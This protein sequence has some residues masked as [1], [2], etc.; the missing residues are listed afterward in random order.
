MILYLI[1]LISFFLFNE[2]SICWT[3]EV[4]NNFTVEISKIYKQHREMPEEES[5]D[6]LL[7]VFFEFHVRSQF[8]Y[9]S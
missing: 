5:V 2:L 7:G 4:F 9:E 6:S 3:N 1:H 8:F